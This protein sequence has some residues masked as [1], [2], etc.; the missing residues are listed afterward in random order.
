MIDGQAPIYGLKDISSVEKWQA[1]LHESAPWTVYRFDRYRDL[2]NKNYGKI[3]VGKAIEF[4]SD[5]YDIQQGKEIGWHE[6]GE[7]IARWAPKKLVGK[8]I[9]IYKMG[10]KEDVYF[11]CCPTTDSH[12][13]VPGDLD[14]WIAMMGPGREE[15]AQKGGFVYFNLLEEL[16]KRP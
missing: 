4:V 3:T 15:P 5:R 7:I 1:S 6:D 12:V 13:A 2:I 16:S 11:Q 9:P 10:K 8:N 14:I